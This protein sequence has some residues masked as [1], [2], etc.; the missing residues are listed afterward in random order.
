M[1]PGVSKKATAGAISSKTCEG[2]SGPGVGVMVGVAVGVGVSV[3][4]ALGVM[5]GV[6]VAVAVGVGGVS[7]VQAEIRANIPKMMMNNGC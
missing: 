2:A 6:C 1:P 5:V 3:G 4:V 7:C